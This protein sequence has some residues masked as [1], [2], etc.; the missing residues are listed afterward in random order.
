MT[1]LGVVLIVLG[2]AF[3]LLGLT[4]A[5]REVFR[6][7][8]EPA[9]RGL[10]VDPKAWATLLKAMTELIKVAPQWFLLTLVGTAL[11]AIGGAML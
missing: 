2:V 3:I 1:V 4:A 10:P 8:S 7:T 6:R 9:T 11:V 5:A